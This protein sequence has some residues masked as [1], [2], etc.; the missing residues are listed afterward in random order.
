MP[1]LHSIALKVAG[2]LLALVQNHLSIAG[3]L[4]QSSE[5]TLSA[6]RSAGARMG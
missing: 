1:G 2:L 5:P 4:L 6:K 3:E